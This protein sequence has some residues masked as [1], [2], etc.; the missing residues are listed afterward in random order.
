[1][2]TTQP[3]NWND[4]AAEYKKCFV[5]REIATIQATRTEPSRTVSQWVVFIPSPA[6]IGTV[7]CKDIDQAREVAAQHGCEIIL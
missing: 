5:R 1:M 3:T 4:Y 2:M 6:V 7:S